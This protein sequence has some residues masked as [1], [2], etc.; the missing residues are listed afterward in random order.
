MSPE[1]TV[2]DFVARSRR[3]ATVSTFSSGLWLAFSAIFANP[4]GPINNAALAAAAIGVFAVW[5]RQA[6]RMA[7]TSCWLRCFSS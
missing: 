6:D 3:S 5:V 7:R 1:P 2:I 4:A